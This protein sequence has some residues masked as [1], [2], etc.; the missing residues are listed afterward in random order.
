MLS[1]DVRGIE[2]SHRSDTLRVANEAVLSLHVQSQ[3]VDVDLLVIASYTTHVRCCLIL[4]PVLRD[5]TGVL[6]N[7]GEF[8]D[9]SLDWTFTFTRS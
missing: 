7:S 5:Q 8:S 6:V 3:G 4:L 9:V 2:V 1:A